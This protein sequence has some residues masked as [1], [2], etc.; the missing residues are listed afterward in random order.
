MK[1]I[2]Y[3]NP[4]GTLGGAETSLLAL[5]G[6]IRKAEPDWPLTLILG[7]DGPLAPK[8]EALGVEVMLLPF[9]S[10]LARLG[11]ASD[12]RMSLV[13]SLLSAGGPAVLYA[14]RLARALQKLRPDLIHTN[15]FKMHVLGS[16][17]RPLET[18]L[19]WHVHDYMQ[20]RPVMRKTL[21]WHWRMCTAVIANSR[22][23]A[24]DMKGAINSRVPVATLYNAIDLERFSPDGPAMDLDEFSGMPAAASG[25][26]RVGLAATFAHWKGQKV[27]LKALALAPANLPLRGYIIGGPIYQTGGSQFSLGELRAEAARLGI[28]HKVGF[29]GFVDDAA[30]A[31]RALDIVVHASTEPEPFGMV[32]AEGMACGKPVI[33]SNAGGALEVAEDGRTGLGH[34]PGDAAALARSIERLARDADLRG[35]LGESGRAVAVRRFNQRRLADELV[36]AYRKFGAEAPAVGSLAAAEL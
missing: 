16:W 30:A 13:G 15:G 28:Q 20:S 19:V 24:D 35:R 14:R 27:F 31:M 12:R 25:V 11:Q 6:G 21:A 1:H 9:P 36:S 10:G 22:S 2:V 26:I 5:L 34:A 8:A 17:A 23:V 33:F 29:T 7:E 4:N 18:P 32:I 3:L